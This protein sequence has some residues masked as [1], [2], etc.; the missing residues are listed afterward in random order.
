MMSPT[1]TKGKSTTDAMS[2]NLAENWWLVLLRGGLAIACGVVAIVMPVATMLALLLIFAA[3]LLVDGI[4]T[5]VS[6]VRNAR[7][8][9]QWGWL[10]LQGILSIAAAAITVVWPGITLIVYVWLV[11]AWAIASGALMMIA[12]TQLNKESGRWWLGLGGALYTVWGI[13]LIIAPFIGALV[14]TWWFGI[15]A[16]IFGVILVA[17]GFK[18]RSHQEAG[19]KTVAQGA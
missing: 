2:A 16:I 3:Y 4:F 6:A 14:M 12:A 10:V 13:L 7:K 15:W 5:I 19:H 1:S 8:G 18:L 17:L 9:E 11:A